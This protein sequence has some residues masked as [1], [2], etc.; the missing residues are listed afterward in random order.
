M[1]VW[2]DA[3]GVFILSAC[4]PSHALSETDL[5]GGRSAINVHVML[6]IQSVLLGNQFERLKSL[7]IEGGG[8]HKIAR[9]GRPST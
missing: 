8:D 5:Q 2:S 9:V 7:D 1:C 6:R 3:P 4:Y